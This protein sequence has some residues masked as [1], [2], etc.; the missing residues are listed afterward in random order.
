MSGWDIAA[1]GVSTNTTATDLDQGS[2]GL[3]GNTI[4]RISWYVR[5]NTPIT[6]GVLTL[7]IRWT[8]GTTL[9]SYSPSAVLLT[10]LN[11]LEGS[12]LIMTEGSGNP[13]TSPTFEIALTS[14]LGT[15]D[16]DYKFNL[17]YVTG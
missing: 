3:A 14:V 11:F 9:R 5:V 12:R 2:G 8:D 16:Y 13:I 10:G 4:Y 7:T 6:L 17:C 15:P 1:S